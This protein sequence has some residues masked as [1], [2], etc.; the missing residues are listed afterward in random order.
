MQLTLFTET[1]ID[2]A[3]KLV[4]YDGKCAQMHGHTWLLK[5]W[6]KGDDSQKDKVGILF[7]FGNINKI[8]EMLDH[9]I[10]NDVIVA[11]PTA[12]NISFWIYEKL[13]EMKPDL[14]FKVRL[15]ETAVLK[16]TYCERS[17]F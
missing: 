14:K 3:H 2:S 1:A 4:G 10:I 13:K 7:D 15:Y 9:Q 6:V 16:H 5:V 12:E 17:D 11:N 8:K